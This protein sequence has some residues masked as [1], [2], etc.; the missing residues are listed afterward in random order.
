ME[1]N[2]D[3]NEREAGNSM[4]GD[5]SS[6]KDSCG[7]SGGGSSSDSSGKNNNS[8][9]GS[10]KK[11]VKG[12]SYSCSGVLMYSSDM[13]A[14]GKG[15]V[16]VGISGKWKEGNIPKQDIE[17]FEADPFG[18]GAPAS[19]SSS[20]VSRRLSSSTS[21]PNTTERDRRS[22]PPP[23]TMKPSPD[24]FTYGCAGYSRVIM[25]SLEEAGKEAKQ[26]S[27]RANKSRLQ[28]YPTNKAKRDDENNKG[29]TWNVFG[30][31]QKPRTAVV[32]MPHCVMGV[33]VVQASPASEGA[34]QKHPSPNPNIMRARD[35]EQANPQHPSEQVQ[36]RDEP[37]QRQ[38][39][40]KK[41]N[42]N[43]WDDIFEDYKKAI[44]GATRRATNTKEEKQ[45][46][47]KPKVHE[48]DSNPPSRRKPKTVEDVFEEF[49]RDLSN[50]RQTKEQDSS[51]DKSVMGGIFDDFDRVVRGKK[52]REG[53]D[54]QNK[55]EHLNS[56]HQQ[57][58]QSNQDGKDNVEKDQQDLERD[59][60]ELRERMRKAL[61]ENEMDP[62]TWQQREWTEEE[63][64]QL[65][66]VME[67][68]RSLQQQRL[69]AIREREQKRQK[70]Q[71]EKKKDEGL[72]LPF[73]LTTE[74]LSKYMVKTAYKTKDNMYNNAVFVTKE[75]TRPDLP[76]RV[77]DS[78]QRIISQ[79]GPTTE[80]CHKALDKFRERIDQ[81]I[82]YISRGGG[83][84]KR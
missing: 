47:T 59:V 45:E 12:Y 15:P 81:A 22:P 80:L 1:V 25:K 27:E 58:K 21:T 37:A 71:A 48:K 50:E 41:S 7:G 10:S 11:W 79:F 84:D 63:R 55:K 73:G 57:S 14:E 76:S 69:Q 9:N 39:E 62:R 75:L 33:N 43:S 17:R 5:K 67:Q 19:T 54:T 52:N 6:S 34:K 82:D 61:T 46:F 3:G 53:K 35:E 23:K 44:Q 36:Q 70:E 24:D 49:D 60:E 32:G 40:S 64:T 30:K 18:T 65:D 56:H 20:P 29:S 26:K 28:R 13:Q 72:M 66:E 8:N 4:E 78:S 74:K 68:R 16:C 38:R 77:Y 51:S 83:G 2:R 42:K 31:L